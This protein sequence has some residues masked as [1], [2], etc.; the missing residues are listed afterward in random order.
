MAYSKAKL[1]SSGDKALLLY[2]RNVIA[3]DIRNVNDPFRKEKFS[4]WIAI[5]LSC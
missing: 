1:K 3:E 4:L 5:L 2:C